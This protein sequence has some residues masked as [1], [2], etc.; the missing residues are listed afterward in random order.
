MTQVPPLSSFS[1]ARPSCFVLA[2]S[3]L[4]VFRRSSTSPPRRTPHRQGAADS[5]PARLRLC[6]LLPVCS[7]AAYLVFPRS[8]SQAAARTLVE[9]AHAVSASLEGGDRD[10]AS[11]VVVCW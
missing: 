8:A 6:A 3:L 7:L 4:R 10:D 11:A 1:P 9:E 5:S 2:S